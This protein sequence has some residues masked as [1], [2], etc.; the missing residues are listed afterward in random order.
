MRGGLRLGLVGIGVGYAV[1]IAA[2]AFAASGESAWYRFAAWDYDG[3]HHCAGQRAAVQSPYNPYDVA[4]P[5]SYS[6]SGGVRARRGSDCAPDSVPAGWLG[7]RSYVVRQDG[8]MCGNADWAY[9]PAEQDTFWSGSWS[10]GGCP[11]T[12]LRTFVRGA[13][14]RP[15]WGNYFAASVWTSTPW[16]AAG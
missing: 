14:Y 13:I 11:A 6:W 9:N 16:V 5:G 7:V 2:S 15:H 1:G 4:E 3:V 8:T 10:G 12:Y